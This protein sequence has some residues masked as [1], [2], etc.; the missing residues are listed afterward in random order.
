MEAQVRLD[1]V[2]TPSQDVV[3]RE[4]DGEPIIV[5]ITSGI[6]DMEDAL[7]TLNEIGKAIWASLDGKATLGEITERF[8]SEYDANVDEIRRDVLGFAGELLERKIIVEVAP[9]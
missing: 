4:I 1:G 6:G 7:Y 9:V 2:Y 3:F 8:S 5:P